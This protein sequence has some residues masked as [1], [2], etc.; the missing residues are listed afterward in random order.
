MTNP[1]A[2]SAL[3]VDKK[4]N[5][6]LPHSISELKNAPTP[7]VSLDAKTI[8]ISTTASDLRKMYVSSSSA[9]SNNFIIYGGTGSGKTSLLR[10]CRTPVLL[11]S[12]D[13]GGGSVLQ[14][15]VPWSPY[16]SCIDNGKILVD[17]RFEGEDP[18]NPSRFELWDKVY[19]QLKREDFFNSLGTYALDLTTFSQ[20]I[21]YYI[22]KKEGRAGTGMIM[23]GEGKDAKMV[24]AGVPHQNDWMPQMM[25]IENSIRDLLSYSC[26]V[27]LLGHDAAIKDEIT[28]GIQKDL[29]VTGKLTRRIPLLFNEMYHSETVSSAAGTS[30]K[31]L[32]QKTGTYQAKTR[33]GCAGQLAI[34]EN[35]DIKAILKK[36][37]RVWEDKPNI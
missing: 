16:D 13:P 34:R 10:S 6:S 26:D 12:F 25:Y 1:S 29:M 14:S 37:G 5:L 31:L 23:K 36:C 18:A 32:T 3:P 8:R 4:V 11:H 9:T 33:I 30:Y 7:P 21:M 15:K 19:H 27:I 35:A 24:Y 28:G 20:C 22:L 2:P 17:S